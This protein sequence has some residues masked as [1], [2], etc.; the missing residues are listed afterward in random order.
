MKT[1]S[2]SER[3][4]CTYIYDD[5]YSDIYIQSTF[6]LVIWYEDH[7]YKDQTNIFIQKDNNHLNTLLKGSFTSTDLTLSE[8]QLTPII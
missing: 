8:N 2:D 7:G 4:D 3:Q 6:W 1:K 5:F